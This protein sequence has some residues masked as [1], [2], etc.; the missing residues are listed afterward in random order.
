MPEVIFISSTLLIVG[1][2]TIVKLAGIFSDILSAADRFVLNKKREANA[3]LGD[4]S[5][6]RFQILIVIQR[7]ILIPLYM[8]AQP[9][10]RS[11]P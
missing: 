10:G 7:A 9:T 3:S 4:F 1:K 6:T 8:P 5:F 11:I 2:P